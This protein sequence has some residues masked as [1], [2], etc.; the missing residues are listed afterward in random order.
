LFKHIFDLSY[1]RN[2]E[3]ALAFYFCYFIFGYYV[4]GLVFLVADFFRFIPLIVLLFLTPFI[5]Y[6]SIAVSTVLKKNLR[7]PNSYCLVLYI[8]LISLFT[9]IL[10]M[11]LSMLLFGVSI[12]N[13]KDFGFAY[14]GGLMIWFFPT[15]A[16]AGIPVA[17]L[18]TKEDFSINRIIKKIDKEEIS[19]ARAFEKEF[20]IDR[21]IRKNSK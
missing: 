16:L 3:E 10:L 2:Y 6:T 17:I 5:F 9:P 1:V 13:I 4:C 8:V 14:I 20:L 15:L 11:L 18:S 7:N 19:V 12:N 21:I